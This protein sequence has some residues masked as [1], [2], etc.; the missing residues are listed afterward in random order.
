[1]AIRIQRDGNLVH[2]RLDCDHQFTTS[3]LVLAF[4]HGGY[5]RS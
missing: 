4:E 5:R 1:M 3:D 2:W